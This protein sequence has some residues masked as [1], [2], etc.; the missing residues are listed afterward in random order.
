MK[1][2]T[3]KICHFS[4]KTCVC[5]H[6]SEPI[7]N[8]THVVVLQH[9]SELTTAKNTV[10]LLS[11]Q[12]KNIQVFVGEAPSDFKQ[13]QEIARQSKCAL[14]YPGEDALAVEDIKP[15]QTQIDYL[16]VLDGTWKKAH[17]LAMLNPW[18][19][20]LP[21]VSFN[22]PPANQYKIR[23][24]EQQYSLST[25][26]ACAYFLSAYDALDTTPLYTLLEGMIFEQTK[27][28]PEHVKARYLDNDDSTE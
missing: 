11:L 17:K 2:S 27:F 21:Q 23:K 25:L 26:E 28:M 19:K 3:C 10:R 22:S 13:A 6:I 18:L 14:L 9:P 7:C 16:F 12:L 15:D 24:A 8:K 20:E 4:V 5:S 1:R